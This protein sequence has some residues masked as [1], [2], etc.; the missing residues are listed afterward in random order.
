M[1][2]LEVFLI[3]LMAIS[4]STSLVTEAVKKVLTIC[5]IKYHAD[6]LAG[7]VAAVLSVGVGIGYVFF[8]SIGFTAQS[9]VC[10]VALTFMSWLGSMV[11]YDKVIAHIKSVK[12]D[13]DK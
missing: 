6:I 13:D 11:G 12:K 5:N 2:T 1:I 3:G 9:I 10:I 7:I 8:E 4:T